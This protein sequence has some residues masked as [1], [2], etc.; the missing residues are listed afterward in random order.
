[1][2]LK[3]HFF[4]GSNLNKSLFAH[5]QLAAHLQFADTELYTALEPL[6]T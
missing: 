1:M 6:L 4:F 3:L 5:L 2:Y